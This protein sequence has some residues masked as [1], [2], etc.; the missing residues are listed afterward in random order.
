MGV[1]KKGTIKKTALSQFDTNRKNG[2]IAVKLKDGDEL[3]DIKQTSGND[4]VII[5][6][7]NGKSIRFNEK[8]CKTYGQ[9]CWRC[10]SFLNLKKTMK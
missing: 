7:K 4:D 2:I 5:V 10:K 6:T 8:R 1:T 3:I 9:S